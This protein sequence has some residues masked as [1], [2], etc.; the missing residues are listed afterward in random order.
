MILVDEF[1]EVMTPVT[2]GE[3]EIFKM[4]AGGHIYYVAVP[5]FF[6]FWSILPFKLNCVTERDWQENGA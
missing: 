6:Y 1:S 2:L 5:I 3:F 4:A